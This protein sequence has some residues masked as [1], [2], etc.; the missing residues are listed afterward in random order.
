MKLMGRVREWL[1][2]EWEL[3]FLLLSSLILKVIL[4]SSDHIINLDGVR[5]ISAAQ[6]FADGNFLEGL[7]IDWMPFYSLLIAA[8]HFL[9][10]DWALAGQLI[11]LLAM[12]LALIPLYLLTRELFDKKGAFWTGVAFTI[13]PTLNGHAVGLL[14]DPIFIFF[15]AWSVYFCLRAFQT[16]KI[17]FFTLTA[18]SSTFALCCRLEALLLWGVFLLVLA[19]LAIKNRLER[20]LLLKGISVL[21]GLPLIFGLLLGGS[22]LLVAGPDLTSFDVEG[23]H[24]WQLKDVVAGNS[25]SYYKRKVSKGVLRNYQS[26]YEKLKDLESAL[27]GWSH[28]GNLLETTRHYMPLIY[29][30]SAVE[31]LADNLFSFFVLPLLFGFGKRLNWHRGHW[32]ILLLVC[33]YFLMGYYFLF[34][35]DWISKRYVLVPALLLMPWLGRGLERIRARITRFRWP[36]FAMVLFL[37]VFCVVPVYKSLGDFI[38]QD[39]DNVVKV[40]GEWLAEQPDLKDALIASNDPRV[41]FYANQELNFIRRLPKDFRKVEAQAIRKQADLLIIETSSKSLGQIPEFK[42]FSLLKEFVGT[43]NH[44]RIYHRNT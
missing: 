31:A 44:V 15:V 10:R 18:L 4:L 26:R 6:Q 34:T 36:R 35:H 20:P 14:R 33:A 7:R 39:K 42:K 37:L 13:C 41:C 9:V 40:A 23:E 32:L 43:K 30:F 3:V 24:K 2:G 16:E 12:V 28:G 5:Y 22:V 29:L 21:V 27:P 17:V 11:S 1:K 25:I 38:G 19:A 8:F